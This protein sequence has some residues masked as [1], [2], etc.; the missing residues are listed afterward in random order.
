MTDVMRRSGPGAFR[1][2]RFLVWGVLVAF[3]FSLLWGVAA[4]AQVPGAAVPVPTSGALPDYL[5][6]LVNGGVGLYAISRLESALLRACDIGRDVVRAIDKSV[7]VGDDRVNDLETAI[8]GLNPQIERL[9][10]AISTVRAA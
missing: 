9:S 2:P 5:N 6:V 7:Q 10:T 1:V 8:R 3:A 4:V